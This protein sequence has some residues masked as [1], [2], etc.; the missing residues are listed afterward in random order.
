MVIYLPMTHK[1]VN[2]GQTSV[3]RCWSLIAHAVQLGNHHLDEIHDLCSFIRVWKLK[4]VLKLPQLAKKPTEW[5]K[6]LLEE[7]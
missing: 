6:P 4:K 2:D 7:F 1:T 5:L 3:C